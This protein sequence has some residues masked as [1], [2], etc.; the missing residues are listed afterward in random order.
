LASRGDRQP[1]EWS[2]W[3][4]LTGLAFLPSSRSSALRGC[5]TRLRPASSTTETERWSPISKPATARAALGAGCARRG[6]DGL[7]A[8]NT[9]F[10]HLALNGGGRFIGTRLW[11]LLAWTASGA[12]RCRWGD[13]GDRRAVSVVGGL[14]RAAVRPSLIELRALAALDGVGATRISARG[15]LSWAMPRRRRPTKDTPAKA[16]EGA[17]PRNSASTRNS[18][19]GWRCGRLNRAGVDDRG[20]ISRAAV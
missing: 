8:N 18:A 5:S 14:R 15:P 13:G 7:R 16:A 9:A 1:L 12:V 4:F 6:E 19:S 17:A 3:A 20:A 2:P 10:R 11:P